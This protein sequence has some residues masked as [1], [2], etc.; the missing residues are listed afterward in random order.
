VYRTASQYIT[1]RVRS[2]NAGYTVAGYT[3]TDT[4]TRLIA[5]WI[6]SA[7]KRHLGRGRDEA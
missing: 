2:C 3:V 1:A 4:G 6:D 7:T 5:A